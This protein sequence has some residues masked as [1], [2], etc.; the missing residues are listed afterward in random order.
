[1]RIKQPGGQCKRGDFRGSKRHHLF[2]PTKAVGT[3]GDVG[4]MQPTKVPN[5][6]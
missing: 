2:L 6:A 4:G 1:M 3:G 5:V